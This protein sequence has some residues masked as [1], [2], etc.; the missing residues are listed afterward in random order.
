MY[1]LPIKQTRPIY[2]LGETFA[3][4]SLLIHILFLIIYYQ[5]YE[6]MKES[7]ELL[8]QIIVNCFSLKLHVAR[9]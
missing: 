5:R 9:G 4:D 2:F 8:K 7:I 1:L 3:L 6:Y